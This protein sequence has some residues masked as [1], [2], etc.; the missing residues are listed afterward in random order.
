GA[1]VVRN[2][3]FL[4]GAGGERVAIVAHFDTANIRA[5]GVFREV[6]GYDEDIRDLLLAALRRLDPPS[7]GLNYSTDDQTADGPTHGHWL[8]LNELLRGTPY[9]NR[10]TSAAP[11]L[12]RLRG[13][14]SPEELRRIRRAVAVTE[15][16]VALVGGQLRP[17]VSER[18]V[19]DFVHAEFRR[20]G[21][22]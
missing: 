1:D 16:V 8:L 15:E 17:G 14:K 2:S 20:R 11:L 12:S 18:Q 7:V 13:R 21:V 10:L 22:E 19:A 6:I 9:A 5:N 3:A 4:F